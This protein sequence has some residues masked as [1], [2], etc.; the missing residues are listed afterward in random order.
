MLP[1]FIYYDEM[2]LFLLFLVPLALTTYLRL[3]TTPAYNARATTN[4]QLLLL[5]V[6]KTI[7]RARIQNT[8]TW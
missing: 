5:C 3:V 7:I 1:K 2:I 4:A 8:E 6:A